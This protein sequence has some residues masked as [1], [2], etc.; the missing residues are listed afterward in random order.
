MPSRGKMRIL[1]V[2]EDVPGPQLGGLGKH[3]VALG[4]ALLRLGHDVT[5]LGSQEY[6]YAD[7]A[8]ET[9]F[10]GHF[11]AGL[12]NVA[13]WA[14][15]RFGFFNPWKRPYFARR[16][17]A[18]IS[19]LARDFDVVHYHGHLPMVGRYVPASV[20]FL[21]TRHDQGSECITHVRYRNGEVCQA[22]DPR[23]C[24]QCAHSSP[25]VWQQGL[26]AAA[27]R[28]YR[29]E[30][31]AA[32]RRHPVVY[33]SEFLRTNYRRAV[34]QADETKSH[35]I[36]NFV[37]EARLQQPLAPLAASVPCA[38]FN[39]HI[40]GRLDGAKG[41]VEFLDLVAPR[42]PVGWM[43]RLYGTGPLWSA[44]QQRHAQHSQIAVMGHRG[45]DETMASARQAHLMVVPS[46]CEEA[47][48]TVVLEALRLGKPCLAL[49]RGATPELA[50]YG[51]PDQLRLYDTLAQMADALV[52]TDA[53]RW[54]A[55]QPGGQSADISHQM[56]ALLALYRARSGQP[57]MAASASGL[58]DGA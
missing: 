38:E 35:V 18:V 11:I 45:Y 56:P 22:V 25:S 49:N 33:V 30:T 16:F 54:R 20:P 10:D 51:G 52:G 23:V 7:C 57:M 46:K 40:A 39:I 3:V 12:P 47:C 13:G 14:E 44:L 55:I 53:A 41:I 5:L 9:G 8:S 6:D 37:H 2:S 34:P 28:R 29:Q 36:H 1:L 17:A 21:Q 24:A 43:I 48:A 27:V 19:R 31:E 58:T 4:N 50:R 32:F 26:T 42:L 15:L